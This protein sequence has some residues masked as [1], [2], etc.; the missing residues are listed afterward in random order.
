MATERRLSLAPRDGIAQN[1]G[2]EMGSSIIGTGLLRFIVLKGRIKGAKTVTIAKNE[3]L[4]GLHKP[5]EFILAIVVIDEDTTLIRYCRT[6]FE[7]EPDFKATMINYELNRLL[8][9]SEIP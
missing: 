1:V 2:Y 5:N 9:T 3:I 4:T 7:R 8:V 6:P